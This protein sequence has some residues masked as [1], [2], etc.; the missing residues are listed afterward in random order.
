MCNKNILSRKDYV[1]Y[2]PTLDLYKILLCMLR[3]NL[4]KECCFSFECFIRFL[5][6]PESLIKMIRDAKMKVRL[7]LMVRIVYCLF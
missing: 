3:V 6:D 7:L 2:E 1:A 4:Y 5:A